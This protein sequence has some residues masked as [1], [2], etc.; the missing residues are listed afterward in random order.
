MASSGALRRFGGELKRFREE[1]GYKQ[2]ELGAAVN[3]SQATINSWE[4]GRTKPSLNDLDVLVTVLELSPKEIAHL[5]KLRADAAGASPW[6]TYGIGESLRPFVSLEDEATRVT[7]CQQVLMPGLLQVA[8]YVRALHAGFP[9]VEIET[10]VKV[11]LR[12]QRRLSGFNPLKLHAVIAESV[13]EQDVGGP[14]VSLRQLDS[15]VTLAQRE[16]ITLQ[17]VPKSRIAHLALAG[18]FAMLHF[19][20]SKIDPPVAFFDTP[21][22]GNMA[23]SQRDVEFLAGRFIDV[24]DMA[25]TPEE[26]FKFLEKALSRFKKEAS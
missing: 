12:R 18:S 4:Q 13:L 19:A 2:T 25:A 6:A 20:D 8:D 9:P 16:N 5:K 10:Q 11:R 17:V 24:A 23:T 3:R 1:A 15:L 21:L 26:T 22:G 14:N 7:T